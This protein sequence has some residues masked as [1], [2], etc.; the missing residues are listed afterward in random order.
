FILVEREVRLWATEVRTRSD[1][2]SMLEAR[3]QA[4]EAGR[5][6][7]DTARVDLLTARQAQRAAD[8][9]FADA[10]PRPA[11]AI[12]LPTSGLLGG[13]GGRGWG[14]RRRWPS[15]PA[16]WPAGGGRWSWA[17]RPG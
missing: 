15:S 6:E 13:P 3:L 17:G 12:G 16:R 8:G 1:Y 9:K 10:P 4:G 14:G 2:V 5:A 11:G 7:G